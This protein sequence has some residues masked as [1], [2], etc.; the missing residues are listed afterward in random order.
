[1]TE[2]RTGWRLGGREK[3]FLLYLAIVLAVAAWKF[4]P[5]PWK[6]AL[7]LQTDHFSIAS[8]ASPEQTEE[9]G[10]VVEMLYAAYSNRFSGLSSFQQSHPKLRLRLYRDREEIRRVNRDMGWAEA[11]YRKPT[12]HAY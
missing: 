3:R 9:T 12:C 7:T 11:F 4:I 2:E 5:R 1:M 10:R 6:P 8:T